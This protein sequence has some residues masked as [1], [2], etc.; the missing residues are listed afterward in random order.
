MTTG[1]LLVTS[2]SVRLLQLRVS[3]RI[4]TKSCRLG[5]DPS[6]LQFKDVD[7]MLNVETFVSDFVRPFDW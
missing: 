4:R 1:A 3:Y 5:L 6:V 7:E 2:A